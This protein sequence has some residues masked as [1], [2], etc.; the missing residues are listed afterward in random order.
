M[1]AP[2][3]ITDITPV[4]S[5]AVLTAMWCSVAWAATDE[6]A[7]SKAAQEVNSELEAMLAGPSPSAELY[8]SASVPA[9]RLVQARIALDGEEL[10][11]RNA[12]AFDAPGRRRIFMGELKPGL[13]TVTV[14]LVY[15]PLHLPVFSYAD[16]MRWK[17]SSRYE[18][19]AHRGIRQRITIEAHSNPLQMDLR[20]EISLS[21]QHSSRVSGEIVL[22][23]PG[24]ADRA[25]AKALE[26]ASEKPRA[27][28]PSEGASKNERVAPRL[29]D[30]E[31]TRAVTV[32][33]QAPK[34]PSTEAPTHGSGTAQ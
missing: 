2:P 20:R 7:T 5:A 10:P 16:Q 14:Q 1:A 31:P 34:E 6:R 24:P 26:A 30:P 12:E 4:R 33:G 29:G 8:L 27:E 28:A 15:E 25:I 19:L 17:V 13:H 18:F 11:T 23:E 22:V 32:A 21:Y 3:R 9:F